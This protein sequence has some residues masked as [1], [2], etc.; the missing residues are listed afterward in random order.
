M[1]GITYKKGLVFGIFLVLV[2]A[3]IAILPT[4]TSSGA[5]LIVGKPGSGATYN[6]IQAAVNAANPGDTIRVWAGTYYENVVIQKT[7][8]L[9][10]NGTATTTIDGTQNGDVVQISTNNANTEYVNVSGFTITNSSSTTAGINLLGASAGTDYYVKYCKIY[11]VII[12]NNAYGINLY[13]ADNNE[14]GKTGNTTECINNTINSIR[15]NFRNHY[16]T[17]TNITITQITINSAGTHDSAILLKDYWNYYNNFNNITITENYDTTNSVNTY[18]DGI[19][20]ESGN[21]NNEIEDSEIKNTKNGI[22][23]YGSTSVQNII[24]RNKIHSNKENG[25]YFD[26]SKQ[27]IIRYHKTIGSDSWG[28]YNNNNNHGIYLKQTENINV[29]NN[30]I[31][32]NNNNNSNS[33]DGIYVEHCDGNSNRIQI[34]KNGIYNTGSGN[35]RYGIHLY[36][37]TDTLIEE[38]DTTFNNTYGIYKNKKD[39]IYLDSCLDSGSNRN[40]IQGNLIY[41]NED[42]GV[43]LLDSNGNRIINQSGMD[44]NKIY[45]NKDDG[46]LL[47]DSD[48]NTM[49]NNSI[50]D[51][52]SEAQQHGIHLK[53]D[54]GTGTSDG[55]IIKLNNSI[56]DNV[57]HGIYL[58]YADD[59]IINSSSIYDNNADNGGTGDGIRLEYSENNT[60]ISGVIEN[61]VGGG[62]NQI[63]GISLIDSDSNDIIDGNILR[64]KDDGIY[65]D[66]KCDS[67]IIDGVIISLNDGNGIFLEGTPNNRPKNNEIK[68]SNVIQN[69]SENGIYLMYCGTSGNGN[70]IITGNNIANNTDHG[71]KLDNSDY[72][73]IKQ[74][75]ILEHDSSGKA[76]IYLYYS[77]SN[78]IEDNDIGATNGGN[79][80]GIYLDDSC[81][82]TITDNE[83]KDNDDYG[84]KISDQDSTGNI[85]Y[86]NDFIDNNVGGGGGAGVQAYDEVGNTWHN[87]Y[88]DPLLSS[89]EGGNY[90]NDHDEIGEGAYDDFQGSNQDVPGNDQIVDLGNPFGGK[91]EYDIDGGGTK[92]HYPY[93]FPLN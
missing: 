55:N 18:F 37:T 48:Y 47:E 78:T 77:D 7:L 66:S 61:S 64:N 46:I 84:I 65:L 14:I 28:I 20:F 57:M 30:W 11:E 40:T 27:N 45:D 73:E 88:T 74:N 2:L 16:N 56:H 6:S 51:T 76:G 89:S 81:S 52:G 58:E 23:F 49:E 32:D 24:Q 13:Y 72:T 67:N 87:G 12:T 26:L 83:I 71:I 85:V 29:N 38:H 69:N 68:N 43:H 90:W 19:E 3:G 62:G 60:I 50:Y 44:R 36:N 34:K 92:D 22:Y 70:K 63:H 39:G 75:T 4:D 42:N 79:D 21:S 9:I 25:I 17:F 10:G 59:N 80:F 93:I 82:N 91:N 54:T 8:S 41:E 53:K 5:I 31:Y 1:R 33:G 86:H 35:Q 15:L